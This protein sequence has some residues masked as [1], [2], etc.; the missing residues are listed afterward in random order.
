MKKS[1]SKIWK[2]SLLSSFLLLNGLTNASAQEFKQQRALGQLQKGWYSVELSPELS[3]S[4]KPDMGDMRIWAITETDTLE[5]PYYIQ[6]QEPQI[7][8]R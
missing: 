3:G 7:N 1:L 5:A 2:L 8:A 6:E 4:L